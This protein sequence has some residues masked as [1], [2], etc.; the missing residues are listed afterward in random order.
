LNKKKV[1]LD[2]VDKKLLEIIETR[3]WEKAKKETEEIFAIL[4]LLEDQETVK[5][6]VAEAIADLGTD[7]PYE[8]FVRKG[9][10]LLRPQARIRMKPF[11]KI[12]ASVKPAEISY[13]K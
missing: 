13:S 6:W 1:L 2:L 4:E 10:K 9:V 11:K 3:D 7:E 12:K 8:L 5:N